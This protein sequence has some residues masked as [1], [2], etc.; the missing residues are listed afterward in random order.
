VVAALTGSDI[1][2]AV[3][4]DVNAALLAERLSGAATTPTAAYLTVGTGVGGALWS[5]GRVLRGANHSEIGHLRIVP[6]GDDG[7]PGLCPAH[8]A[9]LEGMASGPALAAR[10]GAQLEALDTGQRV[11]ARDLAAYYLGRGILDVIAI[12]PVETVVIGGGVAHLDGFHEAVSRVIGEY[13]GAYPPIPLAE[14]GPTVVAPGLGDDAGVI[15]AI[16][17]ARSARRRFTSNG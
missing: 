5:D 11:E 6:R 13:G 12:V 3:D 17:L 1:P 10:F 14:G 8:G 4:T 9:C 2:W 7:F 15:G 16:A